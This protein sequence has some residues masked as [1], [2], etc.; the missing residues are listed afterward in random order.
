MISFFY[1]HARFK[2]VLTDIFLE[3]NTC[4]GNITYAFLQKYKKVFYST[5][6]TDVLSRG[7]IQNIFVHFIATIKSNQPALDDGIYRI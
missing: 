3:F 2:S 6:I 5:V 7:K 4:H 1:L